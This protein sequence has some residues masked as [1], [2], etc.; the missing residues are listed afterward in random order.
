MLPFKRHAAVVYI[1]SFHSLKITCIF[2]LVCKLLPLVLL[3]YYFPRVWK[4]LSS[5]WNI[6]ETEKLGNKRVTVSEVPAPL[7]NSRDLCCD[8]LHNFA[9]WV[10]VI[11]FFSLCVPWLTEHLIKCVEKEEKRRRGLAIKA[12]PVLRWNASSSVR[13]MSRAKHKGQDP[14]IHKT[15]CLYVG[16]WKSLCEKC[17]VGS[18]QQCWGVHRENAVFNV[19]W[20]IYHLFS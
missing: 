5:C 14:A 11:F 19:L 6:S 12:V 4:T 9:A 3:C 10:G 16:L 2:L 20:Q 17:V 1:I 15:P 8:L 7:Q 18:G 13:N